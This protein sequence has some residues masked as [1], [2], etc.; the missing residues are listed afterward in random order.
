MKKLISLVLALMMVLSLAVTAFA[1]DDTTTNN[2]TVT[3]GSITIHKINPDADYAIYKL[4]H[5]YSYDN[6]KGAYTYKVDSDWAAFF[7]TDAAKA[8]VTVDADNIVSAN[9]NFTVDTA[10]AF[11]Q[12][13][14]KYAQ[15]HDIDP[16]KLSTKQDRSEFNIVQS[17]DGT[18]Y[19]GTFSGLSLGY[20]RVDTSTGALGGLTT[21]KPTAAITSKNGTPTLDKR[22]EED[23]DAGTG[24][25]AFGDSNTAEIG[26]IVNF[27]ITIIAQPG[28]Q[29]YVY[30]DIMSV[31]LDLK[32]ETVVVKFHDPDVAGSNVTLIKD[33]DYELVTG[34]LTEGCTFEIRFDDNFCKTLNTNDR[35]YITYSAVVTNKAVIA[36]TGNENEAWLEFGSD[37]TTTHDKTT[38]YTY[39]FEVI[40]TDA[41]GNMLDGAE[42]KLYNEA[43]GG[44]PRQ[45]AYNKSTGVYRLATKA[46]DGEELT[47][48]IKVVKDA[49]GNNIV[50]VVGL[51]NGTY[52]LEETKVP[53]GYN[54]LTS[55]KAFTISGGNIYA[56]LGDDH[57][58]V[59]GSGVHVENKTGATMPET[60]GM[61]TTLF[62]TI[63]AMMV[64]AAGVLLVTKKRMSMIED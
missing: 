8:Y 21:T 29:N 38:T 51:D 5:L 37:H 10:A 36:G 62:I 27:D 6:V 16:E 53:D 40:K 1:A 47:D 11:A 44:S 57:T 9:P 55:R 2:Q 3:N 7:D 18:S 19:S 31:G 35:L 34:G 17:S 32:P 63:G 28:A 41:S 25:S 30:H 56:D 52:Y 13:A 43:T 4:M 48:T 64:M 26:Q 33:T 58:Y 45:L 50:R 12:L 42:F 22:V 24:T 15:E 49:N 61:G 14:L 60:G 39:G 46:V 54:P 20:Y 23:G 59:S